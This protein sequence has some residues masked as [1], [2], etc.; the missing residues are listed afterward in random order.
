M[1]T[2]CM[3]RGPL[4]KIDGNR[5]PVVAEVV[6]RMTHALEP[7]ALDGARYVTPQRDAR[8]HISIER[9]GKQVAIARVA[10]AD[11]LRRLDDPACPDAPDD[12]PDEIAFQR[13]LA[14]WVAGD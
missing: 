11:V 4:K 9:D 5:Y 2:Y 10:L 14:A 7:Y 8:L 12:D 6:V 13:E 3:A 1:T